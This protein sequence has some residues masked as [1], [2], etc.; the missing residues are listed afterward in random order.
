MS[1]V[2]D[3]IYSSTFFIIEMFKSIIQKRKFMEYYYG[4]EDE[5]INEIKEYI[6]RKRRF[7]ILNYQFVEKY[8]LI[9]IE[10]CKDDDCDMYYVP[11]NNRKMYFKRSMSKKDIC[12]CV[13]SLL[14]E[15]DMESPHRYLSDDFTVDNNSI[16]VD[17]GVAEG[18]FTLDIVEKVQKVVLV[19][20]DLGW[21]EALKKTFC[22]E[23][24]SGKIEIIPKKLGEYCSE[25]EVTL[26]FIY[27]KYGRID[28]VKM[29]IEGAEQIALGG[30]K[31]GW[32]QMG[33]KKLRYAP[34]IRQRLMMRLVKF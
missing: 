16:V 7:T 5:E 1:K 28:F 20:Y 9:E 12:R 27:H 13:R 2:K 14:E 30:A 23:L 10:V 29:D 18:N 26:D 33:R 34:I 21:I 11:Y 8:K 22:E 25:N 32:I 15:Q 4:S 6:Q 19:E 3:I 31:N 17:A 24:K